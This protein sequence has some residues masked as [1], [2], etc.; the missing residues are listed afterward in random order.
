MANGDISAKGLAFIGGWEGFRARLYDDALG[1][2]TIGFGHLVHRGGCS[3]NEPAGFRD[4]ITRAEGLALLRAD[5]KIAERAVNES[6][7]VPLTQHKFDALVSFAF[8]V[9]SGA[10]RDSTLLTVVNG[11]RHA[12]VPAQLMRW[13]NGGLPGLVNRRRAESALY[14]HGVY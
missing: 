6:V 12:D 3:G 14:V 9:G 10:F 4:G 13:T 7:H 2:C 5:A 11:G 1:H 8:N